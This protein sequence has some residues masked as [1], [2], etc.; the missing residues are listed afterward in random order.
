LENFNEWKKKRKDKQAQEEA[1]KKKDREAQVKAGK[2]VA[3]GRELFVY[4][5]DL[6]RDDDNARDDI[7]YTAREEQEDDDDRN[8]QVNSV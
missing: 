3:S 6:F 2:L 1:T 7:D 5:P 4:N 8:G